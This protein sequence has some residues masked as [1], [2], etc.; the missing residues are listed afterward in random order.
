MSKYR[1][2][3]GCFNVSVSFFNG[4]AAQHQRIIQLTQFVRVA[5]WLQ[6]GF[7][8][9]NVQCTFVAGTQA[10]VSYSKYFSKHWQQ[11]AVAVVRKFVVLRRSQPTPSEAHIWPSRSPYV[12]PDFCFALHFGARRHK[13]L[14]LVVPM[15]CWRKLMRN[16]LHSIRRRLIFVRSKNS[17]N[18]WLFW[19]RFG[20]STDYWR[21]T[22]VQPSRGASFRSK[23]DLT[24][25]VQYGKTQQTLLLSYL[26]HICCA[27][28]S[29]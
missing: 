27:M 16:K 20:R 13:W 26:L 12:E 1:Q 4:S 6:P 18:L 10:G 17:Y 24:K 9:G 5:H 28:S 8:Y 29:S 7:S 2:D 3:S 19:R 14:I 11:S 15:K 25:R 21:F 22:V 23:E